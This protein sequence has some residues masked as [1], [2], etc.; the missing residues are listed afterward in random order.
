MTLPA[1]LR[2]LIE[3]AAELRAGG[4]AWVAVGREV[5]RAADTCRR[6]PHLYPSVW[7][8]AFAAALKR[9]LLDGGAEALAVLRTHLRNEDDKVQRDAARA[10]L[11]L[12]RRGP[13]GKGQ[14]RTGRPAGELA[15]YVEGLSEAE[16][17][18]LVGELAKAG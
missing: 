8:P 15:A 17:A 11:T 4:T 13:K 14:R 2:A 3:Q 10:L 12:V 16:L 7:R 18:K 6:W 1:D 5:N 9:H